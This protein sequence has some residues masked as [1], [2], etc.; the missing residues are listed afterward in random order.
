[1]AGMEHRPGLRPEMRADEP[2]RRW[3]PSL[4]HEREFAG[5]SFAKRYTGHGR[6]M[7]SKKPV[8]KRL[9]RLLDGE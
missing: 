7:F 9:R 5:Q 6:K 4:E 8:P 2:M 3:R 1:M